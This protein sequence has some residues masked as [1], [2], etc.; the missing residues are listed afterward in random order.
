MTELA[1]SQAAQEVQQ[2]AATTDWLDIADLLHQELTNASVFDQQQPYVLTQA[3]VNSTVNRGA[4]CSTKRAHYLHA[5]DAAATSKQHSHDK[6]VH[7]SRSQPC[8]TDL[9]QHDSGASG[10]Q[11]SASSATYSDAAAHPDTAMDSNMTTDHNSKTHSTT[12][13]RKRNQEVSTEQFGVDEEDDR[14]I[15]PKTP[16]QGDQA[17]ERAMFRRMEHSNSEG[18]SF[19]RPQ[20][21]DIVWA[22][23]LNHPFWPAQ[24]SISVP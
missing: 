7:D 5:F 13:K 15:Q 3:Y 2:H 1:E 14:D 16:E 21:G 11:L 9:Q 12:A 18:T 4:M 19:A 24:V 20:V 23:V 17:R 6:T 22:K 8:Y 10:M